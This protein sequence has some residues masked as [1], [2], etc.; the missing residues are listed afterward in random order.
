MSRPTYFHLG[1]ALGVLV[2]LVLIMGYWAWTYLRENQPEEDQGRIE[3]MLTVELVLAGG[4]S[5]L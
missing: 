3:E 4:E 5:Q 1:R 2:L